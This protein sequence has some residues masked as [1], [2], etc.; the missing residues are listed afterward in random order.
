M[1]VRT[2]FTVSNGKTPP[3]VFLAIA[4]FPVSPF[5]VTAFHP[6]NSLISLTAPFSTCLE[7][8]TVFI[9]LILSLFSTE[10]SNSFSFAFNSSR[11]APSAGASNTLFAEGSSLVVE[12]SI[13]LS[14]FDLRTRFKTAGFSWFSSVFNVVGV[15]VEIT[16]SLFSFS[17][18][19]RGW[20][21]SSTE[22]FLS[23][24][25]FPSFILESV[26]ILSSLFALV[27]PKIASFVEFCCSDAST[28]PFPRN[29][30]R[31]ATATEAAP[32]LTL[33]IE[34]RN[35]FSRLWLSL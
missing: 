12:L 16:D 29:I 13:P 14:G 20:L 17:D 7:L 26:D 6:A 30:K 24:S 3:S 28:A 18:L 32:K 4:N 5:S 27:T 22:F 25:L 8:P 19:A 35:C 11:L 21:F 23:A 10:S 15:S 1:I 2:V 33:R 9:S 34:K 31:A